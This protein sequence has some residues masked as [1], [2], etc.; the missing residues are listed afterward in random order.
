[1]AQINA[2]E[3]L[4]RT[5]HQYGVTHVFMV[6]TS[7]MHMSAELD[8]LGVQVVTTH[9]EKAAAYM[10]D[11]Y[12]R[13]NNTVGVCHAQNIGAAN[14]A[15]GLR[16]P[17]MAGSPVLA[18]TGGPDPMSSYKHQY[19][20]I[21]DFP[22][23][24]SVTKSSAQIHNARRV[25]DL[26]RQAFRAA[27]SG[28][29]GPVH[30]EI[31]G[32]AATSIDVDIEIPDGDQY[33]EMQ[34]AQA[35]ALRSTPPDEQ[36]RR[37]LD[38]IAAAA[39]PVIVAGGGVY[40]S[41]AQAE[42]VALARA[43]QVPVATSMNAKGSI[44]ERDDLAVGVVGGYSRRSANQT[45]MEADLVFFVGSHTGS[46]VTDGWRLPAAGTEVI[47]LDI[48]G[49]E[50]G[51]SY[52]N[53]V[54]LLGDAKTTL[55]R[56]TELA[57]AAS[58][59]TAR[60][61]WLNKVK[62]FVSTWR[63]DV[64]A[65][66]ASNDSPMRPERICAEINA[67]LSDDAIVLSDTG[68]SGIWTASMIDMKPGQTYLRCAG[69]L[70]WGLPAAIG[71]KCAA[72]DRDVI[73][74]TGDGG[75]YYHLSELETAARYN[76]PAVFVVND[77]SSLSQDLE[78]Y[79]AAYKGEATKMGD[80]MWNFLDVDLAATA[81]TLGC[82]SFRVEKPDDMAAALAEALASGRPTVIDAI[83][84]VEAFPEPPFGGRSFYAKKE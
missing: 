16:D 3:Y 54:S 42:L 68:H 48:D 17:F 6:P 4:A 76:I 2:Q 20:E 80:Q 14:L 67:V 43:L 84:P 45:V 19:Q 83:S 44:D 27:T 61:D 82:N 66:L 7:L 31:D 30:L 33:A 47:Q 37:A 52:P 36:I 59:S 21:E 58:A 32:A 73:L 62:G 51:R 10:A 70:G 60:S 41:G 13:V 53:S 69:S 55:A 29:P 24:K 40:R 57:G 74:F 8:R 71:A 56:M 63:S 72:P 35:P 65:Q 22:L 5:L 64:S 1:M 9:G 25:P 49:V 11:G 46:Q 50:L 39:R 18:M 78:P 77:N 15:A 23:F 38:R 28:S 26:L 81:K 79:R 75:L 34:F 12:A